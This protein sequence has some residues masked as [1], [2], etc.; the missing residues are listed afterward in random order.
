MAK[1]KTYSLNGVGGLDWNKASNEGILY[2]QGVRLELSKGLDKP[3][4]WNDEPKLYEAY[5]DLL[6]WN[7]SSDYD[8]GELP[9]EARLIIEI[10]IKE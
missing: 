3:L 4:S 8:S 7:G 6:S 10:E 1:T 2:L 5:E 9:T